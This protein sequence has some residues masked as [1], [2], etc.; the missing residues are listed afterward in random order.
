MSKN[1]IPLLTAFLIILVLFIVLQVVQIVSK[2]PI[3]EATQQQIETL[4][5]ELDTQV[6]EDIKAKA[7]QN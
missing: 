1:L 5:P 6:L 2:D 4:N 3:P 7:A